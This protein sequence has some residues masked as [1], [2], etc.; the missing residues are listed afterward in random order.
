[1]YF[2]QVKAAQTHISL[3]REGQVWH[4]EHD[5]AL[6]PV[7]LMFLRSKV[8]RTLTPILQTLKARGWLRPDWRA[9]LKATLFCCPLLTMNLTDGEKFPPE[10]SLLGLAMAVE[11]GAESAGE[12]SLIDRTLDEVEEGL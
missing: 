7:R 8:E 9:Y 3:K 12:R 6:H 1:M 11:M 2:P 10:I 5:Y 4:V